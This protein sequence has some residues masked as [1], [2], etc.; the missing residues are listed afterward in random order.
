MGEKTTPATMGADQN[1]SRL[2]SAETAARRE[3]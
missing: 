1:M 2:F 3:V